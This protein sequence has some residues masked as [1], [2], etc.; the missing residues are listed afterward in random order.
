MTPVCTPSAGGSRPRAQ[1]CGHKLNRPECGRF[2]YWLP[3]GPPVLTILGANRDK[4]PNCDL[5]FLASISSY[6]IDRTERSTIPQFAPACS[7]DLGP[8]SDP[9][10]FRGKG[11]T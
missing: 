1:Y 8:Y 5:W 2:R 10:W 6:S 11:E 7:R 4:R 9:I 3:K